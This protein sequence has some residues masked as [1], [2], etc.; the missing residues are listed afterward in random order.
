MLDRAAL[1]EGENTIYLK[2][3]DA[4]VTPEPGCYV[5]LI[6]SRPRTY[7]EG[8]ELLY[9]RELVFEGARLIIEDVDKMIVAADRVSLRFVMRNEGDLPAYPYQAT[10]V[11]SDRAMYCTSTIL[12]SQVI[13]PGS[14]SSGSVVFALELEGP[15]RALLTIWDVRWHPLATISLVLEGG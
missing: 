6:W 15:V 1:R 3:A 14:S 7:G 10:L 5:L 4:H 12:P 11:V 13:M 9:R 2:M 8:P